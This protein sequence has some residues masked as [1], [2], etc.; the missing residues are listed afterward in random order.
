M[1]VVGAARARPELITAVIP[2][3]SRA[4][5]AAGLYLAQGGELAGTC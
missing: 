5:P 3:S 4:A 2:S 1:E